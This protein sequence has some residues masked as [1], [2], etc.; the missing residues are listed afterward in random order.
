MSDE[1]EKR[2]DPP[3][4][5]ECKY[6]IGSDGKRAAVFEGHHTGLSIDPF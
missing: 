2:P 1:V 3:G 6:R 4:A 5:S